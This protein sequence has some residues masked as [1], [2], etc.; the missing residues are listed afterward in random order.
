MKNTKTI[1][2]AI[3]FLLVLMW[4]Y[5]FVSKAIDFDTFKRQI[6]GSYLI[7]GTGRMLPYIL[8]AV[9]A[10]IVVLLMVKAWRKA[11]LITSISLLVLYTGYLLYI[12]KFAPSVP[13]TCIALL[14][15]M[16]WENQLV[17]NLI[18]LPLNI[19]GLIIFSFNRPP[20]STIQTTD[21]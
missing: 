3:V 19:I 18:V 10:V 7:S 8:Q 15:G 17:V 11:G 13:C 12:L 4:V 21:H 14:R 1:G 20:H 16:T 9:H 6:T 5:T 2:E